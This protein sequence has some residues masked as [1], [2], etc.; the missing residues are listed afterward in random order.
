[1]VR[2]PLQAPNYVKD[3]AGRYLGELTGSGDGSVL[4]DALADRVTGTGLEIPDPG[5]DLG[6]DQ[7]IT[8]PAN[9]SD[10]GLE[11]VGTPVLVPESGFSGAVFE[12]PATTSRVYNWHIDSFRVRDDNALSSAALE[13]DD[14][15]S[16]FIKAL[17]A[18][19][20]VGIR[21]KASNKYS[22]QN[23]I[24]GPVV[25]QDEGLDISPGGIHLQASGATPD[26]NWIYTPHYIE[27]S[28]NSTPSTVAYKDEGKHNNWLYT[29]CEWAKVVHQFEDKNYT[30]IEGNWDRSGDIDL[31]VEELAG[32]YGT[33]DAVS[34]PNIDKL[35]IR[36]PGT[37]IRTNASAAFAGGNA[38][39]SAT[40]LSTGT[41]DRITGAWDPASANW[42]A[43]SGTGSVTSGPT[44]F[45]RNYVQFSTGGSAGNQ[46]QAD[47]GSQAMKPQA[48]PIVIVPFCP[49]T[50][51]GASDDDDAV[52]VR[53][54]FYID[55]SNH[56]ELVYDPTDSLGTGITS[57]WFLR[58]TDG[59]TST[60]ADT[61]VAPANPQQQALSIELNRSDNFRVAAAV[62]S[63]SW[64]S[65]DGG[66]TGQGTWRWVVEQTG[67]AA[68]TWRWA[69]GE[70]GTTFLR[71]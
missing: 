24:V 48:Y 64:V 40:D 68:K 42:L 27:K 62:E 49:E 44:D 22:N 47:I 37:D 1:M 26:Q 3:S 6:V 57:N 21:L 34:A 60:H 23:K 56:A 66:P 18:D 9:E 54:G 43:T 59:G 17:E 7:P 52:I 10:F 51:G 14:I 29:R 30:V 55:S 50:T 71:R 20:T 33:I 35:R 28:P 25:R 15:K 12:K 2:T 38:N 16:S 36:S 67:S 32:A 45:G 4:N 11:T 5:F 53:T 19:N 41:F 13:L 31:T 63:G 70:R 8:L 65:I 61:G 69:L 58:V 46:I 39:R